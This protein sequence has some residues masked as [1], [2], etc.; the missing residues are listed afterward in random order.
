MAVHQVT[1]QAYYHYANAS[2][3][4][5]LAL[6]IP[7]SEPLKELKRAP[8]DLPR[9]YPYE[10]DHAESDFEGPRALGGRFRS[11]LVVFLVFLVPRK[12]RK[13]VL[14]SPFWAPKEPMRAAGL[15]ISFVYNDNG[16]GGSSSVGSTSVGSL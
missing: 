4:E 11:I 1:D 6:G 7:P 3:Q 15:S 14:R 10:V 2:T 13:F 12:I 8:R 9:P 5:F 16:A